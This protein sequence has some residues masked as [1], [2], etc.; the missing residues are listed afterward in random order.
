MKKLKFEH[1]KKLK[2]HKKTMD[3]ELKF[4]S[5]N[6][7]REFKS[8]LDRELKRQ[9]ENIEDLEV[10]IKDLNQK[11]LDE[12]KKHRELIKSNNEKHKAEI[13][14]IKNNHEN[15]LIRKKIENEKEIKKARRDL[16]TDL[17][18]FKK[19][20]EVQLAEK[21]L[22][23]KKELNSSYTQK[24]KLE[25][26]KHEKAL[27][28]K[29]TEMNQKFNEKEI[30]N[31]KKHDEEIQV[32]K[33]NI[34]QHHEKLM[35]ATIDN[36]KE[37]FQEKCKEEFTENLQCETERIRKEYETLNQNLKVKLQEVNDTQSVAT[38][39]NLNLDLVAR[40]EES[41]QTDE[42]LFP[43]H[44]SEMK[45][46][47][48]PNTPFDY[49]QRNNQSA[50]KDEDSDEEVEENPRLPPTARSMIS[51]KSEKEMADVMHARNRQEM[52][53]LQKRYELR[54]TELLEGHMSEI[55]ETKQVTT[56]ITIKKLEKIF[57]LELEKM[58]QALM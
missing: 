14:N 12:K 4:K 41:V 11:V 56:L 9:N 39:E 51:A 48:K 15:E 24:L 25:K 10:K 50:Q 47:Q 40:E 29:E 21:L 57:I 19:E 49:E 30:E 33:E 58:C 17:E 44:A 1:E 26:S 46:I 32:M 53:T 7:E 36:I 54:I 28:E 18:N 2:E 5:E 43:I 45:R 6:L 42:Y 34:T 3:R 20:N 16:E 31:L 35:N 27:I 8:K 52:D 13:K 37:E 23:Q 38:I 55:Q 22:T